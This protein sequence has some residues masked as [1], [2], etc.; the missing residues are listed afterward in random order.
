MLEQENR[1]AEISID[2]IPEK[3]GH[4]RAGRLRPNIRHRLKTIV[5]SQRALGNS[6]QKLT[7][8][9]LKEAAKDI[10]RKEL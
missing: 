9:S 4:N 5:T 1:E 6:E 3:K 10:A 2:K 8:G 7:R